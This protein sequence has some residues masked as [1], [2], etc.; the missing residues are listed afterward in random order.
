MVD[1]GILDGDWVVVRKQDAADDGD[2]V[3]ALVD[4]EATV[5]RL[6]R[7]RSRV[8]LDPPTPAHAPL[9]VDLERLVIQG[10]V[11]AVQRFL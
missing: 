2:I 6:H 3:V 10:K 1:A 7:E 9:Y 4:G 5:K 8:R 11:V